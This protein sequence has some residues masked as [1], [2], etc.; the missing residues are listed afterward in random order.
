[1]ALNSG[2]DYRLKKDQTLTLSSRQTS[3]VISSPSCY[4]L[5]TL[6]ITMII[7]QTNRDDDDGECRPLRCTASV[8]LRADPIDPLSRKSILTVW[9]SYRISVQLH[10]EK[11]RYLFLMGHRTP[12]GCNA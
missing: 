5:L 7:G 1:M 8:R 9:Y 12:D 10:A 4:A 6:G 11:I 3:A 2:S